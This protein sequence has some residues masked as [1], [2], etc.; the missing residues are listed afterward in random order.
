MRGQASHPL[1][2]VTLITVNNPSAQ[3]LQKLINLHEGQDFI[4]VNVYKTFYL[5]FVDLFCPHIQV[6]EAFKHDTCTS[7]I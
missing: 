1:S 7:S 4:L 6:F 2:A 3:S 5:K